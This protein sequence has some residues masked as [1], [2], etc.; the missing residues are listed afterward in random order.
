TADRNTPRLDGDLHVQGVAAAVKIFGGAILMRNA[1]G[2]LTKGQTALGL[3]GV[4]RAGELVDN[5]A[6]AAGD[7]TIE[8]EGGT[9]PYANSAGADEITIAD[10]GKPCYAVDD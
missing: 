4:G 10:R 5:T 1:A 7:K 9:F 2:Y 8:W 3:I 6:G